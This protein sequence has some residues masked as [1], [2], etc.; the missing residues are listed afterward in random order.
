[1]SRVVRPSRSLSKRSLHIREGA[2]PPST[3]TTTPP[4]NIE[5]AQENRSDVSS[6]VRH[7]EANKA[8][9]VAFTLHDDARSAESVS[10]SSKEPSV[11][12]R[13]ALRR[14]SSWVSMAQERVQRALSPG[15]S[16]NISRSPSTSPSMF[17]PT[18]PP[19]SIRGS[20]EDVP[21]ASYPSGVI[22]GALTNF[23]RFSALPRTPSAT[24]ARAKSP[25]ASPQVS[26]R[27]SKDAPLPAVP[28]PLQRRVQRPRIKA[29]WPEAMSCREIV[30]LRTPLER[31]AGY[32]NKLNDLAMYD[33]GLAEWV[34]MRQYTGESAS[35]R[36]CMV[37]D[38]LIATGTRTGSS[39]KVRLMVTPA[40][41][42]S[43]VFSPQPRHTSRGSETSAMTFP[44]RP[45]AYSA[46]DLT[47]R[48]TDLLPPTASPPPALPY[49]SLAQAQQ[50][51]SPARSSIL[52]PSPS[53]SL[54]PLP[55]HK[56]SGGGFFSSIGRRNSVKDKPIFPPNQ[57]GRLSKR[58]TA[59]PTPAPRQPQP[60]QPVASPA[61]PGGP[62]TA[63]GRVRRSQTF[64]AIASP[65]PQPDASTMPTNNT[66]PQRQSTMRRPSL[67][68]RAKNH[69]QSHSS[70]Q[71]GAVVSQP[72][73]PNPDFDR[74]VDKLA[75]LLPHADRDILAGYL[76]RAGQDILAIGQ[77]LEDEKNGTLRR[78]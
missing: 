76:R 41:P 5:E 53:R 77:Y 68:T 31:A 29:E 25:D 60:V 26:P 3:V 70:P 42:A 18:P 23:K 64:S 62:R 46:T 50:R 75:D 19:K 32:A 30:A 71:A 45:D 57:S 9:P 35:N 39:S 8:P 36:R 6:I 78:D 4:I 21:Q 1:M 67:F 20:L 28:A 22:K 37:V 61:V 74:Q 55:G 66:H 49:P 13:K 59:T 63:P 33:C 72:A 10:S 65:P 7:V 24:S 17:S 51:L 48:P 52:I 73:L 38:G 16:S 40:T 58:Y 47:T 14:E 34:R 56:S 69:G 27:H 2:H 11:R 15:R 43:R 12:S 54:L 44:T